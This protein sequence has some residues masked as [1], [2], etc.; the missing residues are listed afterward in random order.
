MKSNLGFQYGFI[1]RRGLV[2]LVIVIFVITVIGFVWD[3]YSKVLPIQNVVVSGDLTQTQQHQV[4]QSI[5]PLLTAGLLG[6]DI[7]AIQEKLQQ[8][9]DISTVEVRRI[10]P[11]KL[12]VFLSKQT[13]VAF[14]NDDGFM[15]C[16]G[17]ILPAHISV[18]T[19][20]LPHFYGPDNSQIR[21]F[22]FYQ[23]MSLILQPLNLTITAVRLSQDLLCQIRL[24]NGMV[25]QLGRLAVLD[26]F[27]RFIDYY[28][29]LMSAQKLPPKKVDL[30]YAHG[31]AVVW[32]K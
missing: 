24:S 18:D 2:W 9:P 27:K 20:Q 23:Q 30:R 10:W 5:K 11:N 22:D 26:R 7:N 32:E 15:T 14:W 12:S 13:V 1:S 8:I 28:P 19:T 17:E 16:Y 25:I 31:M 3:Q 21:V 4:Q 6:V 29:K